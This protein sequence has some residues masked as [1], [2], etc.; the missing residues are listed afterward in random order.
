[1]PASDFDDGSVRAVAPPDARDERR[2]QLL[3][4]AARAI[5][6]FGPD[7]S[8]DRLAAE[9][10]I[11]KPVLYDHFGDKAGLAE[12]LAAWFSDRV[13]AIVEEVLARPVPLRATVDLAIESFLDLVEEEPE[14]YRFLVLHPVGPVDRAPLI[15]LVGDQIG[16]RIGATLEASGFERREAQPW[17][18]AVAGGIFAAVEWWRTTRSIS[19]EE[20]IEMTAAFVWAGITDGGQRVLRRPDEPESP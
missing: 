4:A 1:M 10:G 15:S 8:M 5:R 19:R 6:T 17:G 13:G 20:L 2:R 9:A 7:A 16:E 18:H 11:T 14:L 12:A 3:E